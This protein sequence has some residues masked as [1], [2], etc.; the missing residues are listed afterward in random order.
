MYACVTA[1]IERF[2]DGI[3]KYHRIYTIDDIK[4]TRTLLNLF[5][6]LD[7][8]STLFILGKFASEQPAIIDIV[9]EN[10]Y[11]LASHGYTHT[12]LR[13][14][15]THMLKEEMAKSNI[16]SSK[17]FRAPYYGIDHRVISHV[18]HH[19]LY[20]SSRISLRAEG[21]SYIHMMT[22]SLMEI[23][24]STIV[25]LPLTSTGLRFTP[26][27]LLKRVVLSIL[28]RDRHLIMNVHPW[29]LCKISDEV[30]VPFYVKRNTGPSFLKKFYEILQFLRRNG[31]EFI[32][33][34]E[35]YERHRL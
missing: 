11:E 21:V 10:G 30:K 26:S 14:L 35:I 17:G 2:S 20:D 19:Y 34:E 28:R 1:D 7:I 25:G 15:P 16:F 8:S 24:L 18:E 33:M 5:C 3:S 4:A 31:V 22:E 29:E 27:T 9:R 12:D 6:E 13:T 23:P 32:A